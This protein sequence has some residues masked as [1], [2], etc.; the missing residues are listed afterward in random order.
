MLFRKQNRCVTRGVDNSGGT[1]LF[2]PTMP[3]FAPGTLAAV[4][5]MSGWG[6]RQKKWKHIKDK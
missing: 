1:L 5:G 6:G 2:S 4:G 3:L